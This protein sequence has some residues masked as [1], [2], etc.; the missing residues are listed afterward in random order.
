MKYSTAHGL[1]VRKHAI[2]FH[3]LIV[4]FTSVLTSY[5][6]SI[7][8]ETFP[9]ADG[10][11]N[12]SSDTAQN[13]PGW[14]T[15]QGNGDANDVKISNEDVAGGS[16]PPSGGN[17]LTF[18]D[19]DEGFGTPETYDIAYVPIDLSAYVNVQI[20][21][22]WQSDDVDAGEGLRVAFST[23]STDGIDGTWIQ[24]AEYLNPTDDRWSYATYN[25]SDAYAV[26]TFVLRFSSR[27]NVF[28]EH[29][30]V[31]DVSVI[32]DIPP[33]ANNNGGATNI[34]DTT[35]LLQGQVTAGDPTP[36]AYV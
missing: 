22:Y 21:Y 35:A 33:L 28:N 25:L 36:I 12:G 2:H 3:A 9:N 31:D 14:A 20:R 16:V 24:I 15:H 6:A 23:N 19:C 30:Y 5:S 13:E 7:F 10:N 4:L 27:E 11:W 26:G 17:H 32:G 29:M 1:C 34:T 18:E 8:N